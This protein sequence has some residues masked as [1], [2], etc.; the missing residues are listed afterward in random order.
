MTCDFSFA[1]YFKIIYHLS[2]KYNFSIF[3]SFQGIIQLLVSHRLHFYARHI[4]HQSGCNL[5]WFVSYGYTVVVVICF[6][7]M[8]ISFTLFTDFFQTQEYDQLSSH[9][10]HVKHF[11]IMAFFFHHQFF[12]FIHVH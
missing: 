9:T 1:R 2:F 7:F 8:V 6:C 12:K 4:Y 5:F 3:Q 10:I 11:L